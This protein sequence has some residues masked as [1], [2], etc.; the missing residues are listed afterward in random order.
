[1]TSLTDD[2]PEY[3]HDTMGY[4]WRCWDNADAD[5]IALHDAILDS[6]ADELGQ[7]DLSQLNSLFRWAY[8]RACLRLQRMDTFFEVV[9]LMLSDHE[10]D[11]DVFDPYIALHEVVEVV[12]EQLSLAAYNDTADTMVK[13]FRTLRPDDSRAERLHVFAAIGTDAL[14][15]R[16]R[17]ASKALATDPE[18]QF[19]IAEDLARCGEF[20]LALELL[21]ALEQHP[22]CGPLALDIA[23]MR[24]ELTGS[25]RS[26]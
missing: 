14:P 21:D 23:L 5:A 13:L 20:S 17:E 10:A 9:T 3:L 2:Y 4:R 26:Y 8:A 11:P 19:E 7:Y 18:R 15:D 24:A 22:D 1:M 6:S 16:L 12:T 25:P